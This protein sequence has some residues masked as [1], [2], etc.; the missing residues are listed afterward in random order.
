MTDDVFDNQFVPQH[1]NRCFQYINIAERF[2]RPKNAPNAA[3]VHVEN[4]PM[5]LGLTKCN[6]AMQIVGMDMRREMMHRAG[7]SGVGVDVKFV[8]FASFD[9]TLN[10]L[11]LVGDNYRKLSLPPMSEHLHEIL[12]SDADKFF[13]PAKSMLKNGPLKKMTEILRPYGLVTTNEKLLSFISEMEQFRTCVLTEGTCL[14]TQCFPMNIPIHKI[15]NIHKLESP[16]NYDQPVKLFLV[17]GPSDEILCGRLGDTLIDKPEAGEGTHTR[18]T[19]NGTEVSD[20]EYTSTFVFGYA[21]ETAQSVL[22]DTVDRCRAYSKVAKDVSVYREAAVIQIGLVPNVGN[23]SLIKKTD[24]FGHVSTVQI[25]CFK[26]K[27][28]PQWC[29]TTF[30]YAPQNDHLGDEEVLLT[31]TCQEDVT[32]KNKEAKRRRPIP[33]T[34]HAEPVTKASKPTSSVTDYL[35][36]PTEMPPSSR[37]ETISLITGTAQKSK[38]QRQRSANVPTKLIQQSSSND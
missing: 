22:E 21:G 36:V 20:Q 33:S 31:F 18:R 38:F 8:D 32:V 24:R 13:Q 30:Q 1:P 19:V 37:K 28:A 5:I 26:V 16:N 27:T 14:D 6:F 15:S 4:N 12:T 11:R 3:S 35:A 10:E 23:N 7:V 34:S 17:V 9:A 2:Y 29:Y 25:D